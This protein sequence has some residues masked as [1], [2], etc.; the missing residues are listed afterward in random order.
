MAP[1]GIPARVARAVTLALAPRSGWF[2]ARVNSG[3]LAEPARYDPDEPGPDDPAL[4]RHGDV[5][6]DLRLADGSRLRERLGAGWVRLVPGR[7]ASS[8]APAGVTEI[9]IGRG[10]VYGDTRA[11]LVRPDGYLVSS[12]P[13][14]T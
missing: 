3:R 12:R 1:R 13:L 7:G 10:S 5:A 8:A 11:W 14:S 4:P 9:D 6:P 2:R